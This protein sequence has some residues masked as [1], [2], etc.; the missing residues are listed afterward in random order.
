DKVN[1]RGDAS[2]LVFPIHLSRAINHEELDN[3]SSA[4]TLGQSSFAGSTMIV[5]NNDGQSS[6]LNDDDNDRSPELKKRHRSNT[7]DVTNEVDSTIDQ[8][9]NSVTRFCSLLQAE[10]CDEQLSPAIRERMEDTFNRVLATLWSMCPNSLTNKESSTDSTS[11]VQ[12]PIT[13]ICL[14]LEEMKSDPNIYITATNMLTSIVTSLRLLLP[15]KQ[16]K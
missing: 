14:C 2:M 5:L 4:I 13:Q 11:G 7:C 1:V 12:H 6:I 9:T 16:N 8:V 15:A 3:N 10:R